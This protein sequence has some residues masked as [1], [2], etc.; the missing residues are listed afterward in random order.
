MTRAVLVTGAAGYIGRSGGY[1]VLHQAPGGVEYQRDYV[2][3]VDVARAFAVVASHM[4]DPRTKIKSGTFD[5]GSGKLST[6]NEVAEAVTGI[7]GRR[8]NGHTASTEGEPKVL[9]AAPE[10]MAD[11]FGW[12]AQADLTHMISDEVMFQEHQAQD[13]EVT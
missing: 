12:K 8:I 11:V 3:V 5:V 4:R 1:V 10:R 13:A 9:R 2:H 7:L 6:N